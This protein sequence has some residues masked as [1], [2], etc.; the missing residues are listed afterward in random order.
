MLIFNGVRLIIMFSLIGKV[1]GIA[2]ALFGGLV[3]IIDILQIIDAVNV[4]P[5]PHTE[6]LAN[7][8]AIVFIVSLLLTVSGVWIYKISK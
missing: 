5:N 1:Y 4:I 3:A 2:V 8:E 7:A 6:E